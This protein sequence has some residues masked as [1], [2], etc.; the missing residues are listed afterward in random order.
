HRMEE[1]EHRLERTE[2]N[3]VRINDKISELEL[4]VEPLRVQSEKAKKYLILRDELRGLEISVW[5]EQLEKIRVGSMKVLSDF[6]HAVRQKAD[7]QTQV[8]ALYAAAEGYAAKMREKD[9]AAEGIRFEMMQRDADANGFQNAIA[10]LKTNIQNNLEN[11]DRMQR[12]LDQQAGRAGSIT[13]Q[14]EDRR[15]RL[16]GI[17]SEAEALRADLL[18]RQGAAAEASSHAGSLGAEMEALRQKE[19][20]ESASASEA[21]ALLSALAA[22]AQELLDRDEAVRQELSAG[23]D[24]LGETMAEEKSAHAALDQA[25]EDRDALKNIINGYTLRL[26][27]R[28]KKQKDAEDRHVKLQ[29]EENALRS[30]IHML[31]EME[32]LFEGYSKAVK[33]VMGDAERGQLKGIHGPVAGLIHVPDQYAVAIEIALGSAMQNIVVETEEN[34]KQAINYL[35]SRDAGRATFLPLTSIRPSEFRD[36]KV[37]DEPGFV[38][39][40]DELI[41]FDRKY[42][43]VFSSLLG[44]TVI[45]ENMDRAIAIAR[46]YSYHFRI[47]TLDGQVLNPGGSM[48][49]GSVSRSAGILSRANELERLNTQVEGIAQDLRAA[50]LTLEETTR[51]VTAAGYEM[52]TAQAQQRQH[53]DAILTLEE[54]CNHFGTLLS[55]LRRQAEDQRAELEQIQ[56]RSVQT[57]QDTKNARAR[58]ETLEGAAAGLRAEAESKAQGQSE[59]Q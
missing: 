20:V 35:K 43:K 31:S 30:R 4:Q 3:L 44:R 14:I 13:G 10:V 51:E 18:A 29:M 24:R 15:A 17:V 45:A 33:V 49:G 25:R 34:G 46:K 21:R 55:D 26:E 11:T 28:R 38:G 19:A 36:G 39:M 22:A 50:A 5:L 47:V 56:K 40:G 52:E 23:E 58:I 54:R 32:K 48:T 6:E 41:T 27:T 12:E 53:E 7:A 2:E 9:M 8:E 59:I 16:A 1:A 57:E 42:D 37:V